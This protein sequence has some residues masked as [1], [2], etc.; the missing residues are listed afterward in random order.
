MRALAVH[1]NGEAVGRG[2][3]AAGAV[4][5]VAHFGLG[6]DVHAEHG[7]HLG[8][9]EH[10]FLHHEL[11]PALHAGQRA[12][13][14]GLKDELDGA[15]QVGFHLAQHLGRAHEHGHVGVVAA[16]VHHAHGLAQVG[17]FYFGGE[18]QVVVFG[19]GQAVHVGA[20][21]HHGAGLA[22]AQNAH[23]AGAGHAGLHL[24]AQLFEVRG[25]DAGG[26]GF[27]V[28]QLGVLVN[29]A[30]PGNDFGF[31]LGGQLGNAGI[32][33]RVLGVGGG[34]SGQRQPQAGGQQQRSKKRM[35]ARNERVRMNS[36]GTFGRPG[37]VTSGLPT[38]A[39][40]FRQ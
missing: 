29:V 2:H 25:N 17:G 12:F 34:G 22:A 16:G 13:L 10:A 3:F 7:I 6:L 18:G 39:L 36:R 15:G 24:Q 5:E 20:Q 27:L 30:P 38:G 33:G 32:E 14:G 26:A 1:L 9:V 31:F 35:R 37:N 11:G 23:H 19:E 4:A 28:A 21:G 8:L 40:L